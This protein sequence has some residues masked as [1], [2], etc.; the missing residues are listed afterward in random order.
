MKGK[1]HKLGVSSSFKL[2]VSF[3]FYCSECC[4]FYIALKFI[5][6]C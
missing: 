1:T 2:N 4:C 3:V 6:L 5:K